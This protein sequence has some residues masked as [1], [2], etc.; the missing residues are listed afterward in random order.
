MNFT[1]MQ[2]AGN[3]FVVLDLDSQEPPSR[4]QCRAIADRA[5]GIGCDLILGVSRPRTDEAVA[6]YEIW[7]ADGENSSQCGNGAR[8]VAAWIVRRGLTTETSFAIDSPVGTHQIQRLGA[9]RYQVSLGEPHFSPGGIGLRGETTEKEHY[10][11]TVA[12]GGVSEELQYGA[13]SVG[14]PHVIIEYDSVA[15]LPVNILGPTIQS[16]EMLP[17]GVIINFVQVLSESQLRLRVYEFGAGETRSCG[18]GAVATAVYMMR[19]GRV[20]SPVY[21]QMDGGELEVNWD[22]PGSPASLIGNAQFVFEGRLI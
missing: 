20:K 10:A 5:T 3:D 15:D 21:V 9:T 18:T 6:Q 14:N 11:A 4:D 12:I 2:G 19:N 17:Y 1:K 13:V 16:L 22:G 7:T 8:C